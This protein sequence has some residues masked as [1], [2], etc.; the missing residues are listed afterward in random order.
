MR[1]HLVLGP[2]GSMG[3]IACVLASQE[4]PAERLARAQEWAKYLN[5]PINPLTPNEFAFALSVLP[6]IVQLEDS[7]GRTLR[8][9]F[10]EDHM[11]Y[12]RKGLRGKNELLAKALG[13]AKGTHKV[14]DL[15]AGL[16]IDAV[17]MTQLHFK[18][19]SVERS[20]LLYVLL[21]EALAKT[22]SLQEQLSFV[23]AEAGEYL[24]SRKLDWDFD[25]IYFDPM[26]PH[27]KKSALPKQEMMV[28]RELVGQDEDASLVLQLALA[29]EA[30]RI[31]VKRP[32]GAPVLL[33]G[34]RHAFEGKVVRYDVYMR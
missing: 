1:K 4:L 24:Q 16:G 14:L 26:Y 28:F 11:N 12:Q 10:L 8:I 2:V 20:K 3:P 32:I 30:K 18:V 9:D 25:A 6:D 7:Q 27:K 5:A 33:P 31:V 13:L 15:T 22:E 21:S 34:V 17:Y 29:S 23:C 19:V